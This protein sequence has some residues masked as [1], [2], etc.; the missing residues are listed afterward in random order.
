MASLS[1]FFSHLYTMTLIFFTLLLIEVAILVHSLTGSV[2][3]SG[4]RRITTTQFLELIEQKNPT[5]T[6]GS[7]LGPDHVECTVCLSKFEEGEEIRELQCNHTF[8]K[9]CLDRWLQQDYYA[10]C[11][12]CRREVLPAEIMSSYR[13]QDEN[14]FGGSDEEMIFF[15]SAIHGGG[16]GGVDPVIIKRW[17]SA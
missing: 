3:N 8:H 7:G 4:K 5:I 1:E 14:E 9:D 11:P 15:L 12:L 13:L 16:V 6:Y 2:C 10:N 17:Y